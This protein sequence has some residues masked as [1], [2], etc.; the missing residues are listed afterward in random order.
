MLLTIA[1]IACAVK[2]RRTE[3][4]M[5]PDVFKLVMALIPPIMGN[6]IIIM[7]D[8]WLLS[9]IG[10]YMY[11]I[12][13]D[14]TIIA[15]LR[16]TAEYC[17]IDYVG[18]Y[19][20]K[21]ASAFIII[22]IVQMLLNPIFGHAFYTTITMV[23]GSPYYVMTPLYGQMFHRMVVYGIF[24]ISLGI[25]LYKTIKA[26]RIY[27]ERYLVILAVMVVAGI[28]QT[29]YIVSRTPIDRSMIGFGVYGLLIFY[30]ALYY[31]PVRLLDSMLARIV[32]SLDE[33][34]VFFDG[35]GVCIY[36]NETAAVKFGLDSEEALASA[37]EKISSKMGLSMNLGEEWVRRC[38]VEADGDVAFW[39]VECRQ[40]L[41]TKGRVDGS[42]LSMRD[43]TADERNLQRERHLATHDRLTGLYNKERLYEKARELIDANPDMA[44]L[45]VALD[46]KDFKIIND[47]FS[48]EFGD[49][50]LVAIAERLRETLSE[51]EVVAR[52]SGDKFAFLIPAEEFDVDDYE[53]RLRDH[54]LAG[55]NKYPVVIHMGVYEIDEPNLAVSLMFDRAF[56]AIGTIKQDFQKR[57]AFYDSDMREEAI[58]RQTIS[59][60]LDGA[61]ESGQ[62]RPYLQPMVDSEGKVEGAEVLVRWVHPEKGFLSPALFVPVFEANGMIARLDEYMWECACRL[63]KDWRDNGIDLF[64]SVNISPKDFYFIDV[65][66]TIHSL[67]EKYGVDSSKLRLEITE[68]VMMSDVENR[69]RIIEELRSDGFIVEMDDFGSGYSSL[70]ML[71]DIPVDVLKIDMMF[72]YK[73]KDQMKARTILQSIINLSGQLGVPSITEGVE[74]GEQLAMLVDMGCTMF[75][76]YYFAKP[77]PIDEFEQRYRVA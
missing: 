40:L 28:W 8:N 71:K 57:V 58:W 74:T 73:T 25:F 69:L 16:F 41:D 10:C 27:A 34:V 30:F 18:T 75:Q 51:H 68:T 45:A 1:L 26:P 29:F 4:Q 46:V 54:T 55:K 12:G 17:S 77:M 67:I 42:V 44:F 21:L 61:I 63:L 22:D 32:S 56:M 53:R 38:Q 37:S 66:E 50:V 7:S 48:K 11:Y 33:S 60:E 6:A 23:E 62:I 39:N 59:G 47:I 52:L 15:N 76:G 64:L 20:R 13:L 9:N 49:R 35:D 5:A 19:R 43:I 14:L 24:F 72:L 70:N 65:H 2:A 36:A 31:K 3:K